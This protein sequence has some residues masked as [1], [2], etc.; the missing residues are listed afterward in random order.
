MI[1]NLCGFATVRS[2]RFFVDGQ[3][4]ATTDG[5]IQRSEPAVRAQR[6]N[7]A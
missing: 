7:R 6:K 1:F 4:T 3:E 5:A 2:P